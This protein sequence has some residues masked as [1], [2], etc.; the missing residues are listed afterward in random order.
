MPN[1]TQIQ[2][3]TQ[4]TQTQGP[5][6]IISNSKWSEWNTKVIDQ[7]P[8]IG[9][10]PPMPYL[11]GVVNDNPMYSFATIDGSNPDVRGIISQREPYA[12]EELMTKYGNLNSGFG[13]D[14]GR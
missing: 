4:T 3:T 5:V 14:L 1:Q 8:R 13:T 2:E 12:Q 6:P 7:S 10:P 11:K 9:N